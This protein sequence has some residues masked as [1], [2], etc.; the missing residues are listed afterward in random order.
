MK[1]SIYKFT[2]IASLFAIVSC[3]EKKENNDAAAA[4]ETSVT[5]EKEV[6]HAHYQCPMKCEEDKMY[7]EAGACPVCKM[8]L[9]VM[10]D[11]EGH[12]H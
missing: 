1:K 4:E 10:D 12:D 9:V 6:A 7:E 8:D 2:L 5:T 3:G 11:H